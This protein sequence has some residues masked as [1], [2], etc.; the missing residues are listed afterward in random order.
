MTQ[1]AKKGKFSIMEV[2]N[3]PVDLSIIIVSWNVRD[4]VARCLETIPAGAGGYGYEVI[5]VDSAS[6]DGT[7]EMLRERFPWVR[8]MAQPVNVG[9][10]AGNNIGLRAA[11]GRFLMLLNPDTDVIGNALARLAAY[12][13]ANPDVGAVGPHT[14]N[15]DGSTQSS[16]RRF[17]TLATAFLE[18]TPL[19]KI[20]PRRVLDRYYVNGPPDDA[21]LDVDWMQ[22]SA[23]MVRRE[24]YEAVGGLDEGYVMYS[25]EV[26][27]CKR[28]KLAGWRVVYV[29]S[30]QIVH[31]GGKSSDQVVAR[32]HIHFNTSKLRYF[33][34]FHGRGAAAVLR[35]FLLGCYAWMMGV[36]AAKWL[37]G[38][39]RPLRRERVMQYAQVLRSGLR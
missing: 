26:D 3:A 39:K 16:R 18:S 27:W 30:A 12:M 10:T 14:L 15:T 35:V 8:L 20:A 6:T 28:I 1:P 13:E 17:P 7:P 29:G 33:Q 38:H 19:Q 9:F 11:G 25:E 2:Q 37:L 36:E 34:K 5:V 22:G 21:V 23:L 32:R 24:V 31:H 4:Y